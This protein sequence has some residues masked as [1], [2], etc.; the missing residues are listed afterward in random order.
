MYKAHPGQGI[1]FPLA[2]FFLFSVPTDYVARRA[3]S[4]SSLTWIQRPWCNMPLHA[5]AR[6]SIVQT[7]KNGQQNGQ[8][9]TGERISFA[10]AA[11]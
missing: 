7:R 11:R 10:S 2:T 5:T 6:G 3:S 8:R 4:P 9:R 1:N